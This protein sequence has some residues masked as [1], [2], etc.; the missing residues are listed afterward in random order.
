MP[1]SENIHIAVVIPC[2]RVSNKIM[3]VLGKIGDEVKSIYIVDDDCPE[4]SGLVVKN[5]CHDSRVTVVFHDRNRGV[6]GAVKTGY[7][8]A[9]KQG[10]DVIVKIDGDG[11]MDPAILMNFVFP[12][13]QG[14]ADYTKGNRFFNLDDLA[15]MPKIRLFGNS[16]LSFMTKFST[17]YWDLF[18]PT[19]GYTA[20]HAYCIKQLNFSKISDRYFF[21]TDLLFRLGTIRAVVIDIPMM[22]KYADEKSS[23]KI[24]KILSEFLKK[25]FVNTI[26]RIFYNYY[27]RDMSIASIELPL[28][29][30]LLSFGLIFGGVHWIYGAIDHISTPVGTIMLST[31]TSMMGLQLILAFLS[32]DISSVPR[33]PIARNTIAPTKI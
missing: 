10:A 26:K 25:H 20:I 8:L 1:N 24:S 11:Q 29:V 6:G 28:G 16:I 32:F 7:L 21:E 31:L 27:L 22:A 19:N 12:I 30:I 14:Q 18:D 9:I 3:E 23:L 4:N 33:F 2:Y 15:S 13:L 17:G 5:N